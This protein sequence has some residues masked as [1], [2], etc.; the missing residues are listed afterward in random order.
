MQLDFQYSSLDGHR[1]RHHRQEEIG[2]PKSRYLDIPKS[3]KSWIK[4]TYQ[5]A[6]L[7]L[8]F[9]PAL[10]DHMLWSHG[11]SM[12]WHC[13]YNAGIVALSW[14][15]LYIRR[16][17]NKMIIQW[18]S[19]GIHLALILWRLGEFLIQRHLIPTLVYTGIQ[20]LAYI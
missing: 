4:P 14:V 7:K 2:K 1:R 3:T 16:K 8:G 11:R 5:G 20:W 18:A 12:V 6:R 15:F 19:Y 13:I 17:N 9:N 10:E